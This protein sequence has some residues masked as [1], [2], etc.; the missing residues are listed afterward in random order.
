[1]FRYFGITLI[2]GYICFIKN[3]SAFLEEEPQC[4]SRFDYEY[5]V[6]QKLNELENKLKEHQRMIEALNSK[7]A[8][9]KRLIY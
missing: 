4:V 6:V 5:K 7:G 3:M 8:S 9:K 1:M 2:I